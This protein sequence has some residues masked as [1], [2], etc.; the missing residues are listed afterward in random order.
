MG[1][2]GIVIKDP[3]NPGVILKTDDSDGG[4]D[5]HHP[6]C[7]GPLVSGKFCDIGLFIGCRD[8]SCQM[9]PHGTELPANATTQQGAAA[10]VAAVCTATPN[11]VG[12]SL[13]P[14]RTG[15]YVVPLVMQ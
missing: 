7:H 12:F 3:S 8:R 15:T 11:C 5:S 13:L 9:D 4:N 14:C 2:L 1:K 6:T 10:E